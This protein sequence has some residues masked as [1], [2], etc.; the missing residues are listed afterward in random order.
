MDKDRSMGGPG[1]GPR[2]WATHLDKKRRSFDLLPP[3]GV[4]SA[5]DDIGCYWVLRGSV[6]LH[7][8]GAGLDADGGAASS[9]DVSGDV[10]GIGRAVDG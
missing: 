7:A 5:Q 4:N 3:T 8:A 2:V 1:V 6:D 9:V 10:E